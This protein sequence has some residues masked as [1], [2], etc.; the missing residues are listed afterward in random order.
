MGTLSKSCV[1]KT[2]IPVRN[3]NRKLISYS[4]APTKRGKSLV[5]PL[6]AGNLSLLPRPGSH[7]RHK[8]CLHFQ[9]KHKNSIFACA[10]QVLLT[11]PWWHGTDGTCV[12]VPCVCTCDV[13]V[14]QGSARENIPYWNTLNTMRGGKSGDQL[15]NWRFDWKKLMQVW[16]SSLL[17]RLEARAGGSYCAI[18]FLLFSVFLPCSDIQEFHETFLFSL[19][20]RLM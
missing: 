8:C 6:S 7:V 3:D 9:S 14:N 17:L 1:R 18:F 4:I 2:S 20:W 16:S 5:P 12:I 19:I 10:V 13:R 15:K 11:W